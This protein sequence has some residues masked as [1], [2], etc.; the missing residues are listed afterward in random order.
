M[1]EDVEMET[2]EVE[3]EVATGEEE[4]LEEQVEKEEETQAESLAIEKKRDAQSCG[5]SNPVGPE[6]Q[7]SR[8]TLECRFRGEAPSMLLE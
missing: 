7:F 5:E 4:D 8:I 2:A 1:E 3:E 6:C